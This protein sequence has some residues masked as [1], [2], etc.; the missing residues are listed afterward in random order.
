M[1][2]S[3]L[4]TYGRHTI[5][6]FYSTNY[7]MKWKR[8]KKRHLYNSIFAVFA[9]HFQGHIMRR[10][11]RNASLN[12][13][14][15]WIV[16]HAFS[17]FLEMPLSNFNFIDLRFAVELAGRV[18]VVIVKASSIYPLCNE[19]TG[20]LAALSISCYVQYEGTNSG[21]LWCCF[22]FWHASV[23]I[24]DKLHGAL[25]NSVPKLF[26]YWQFLCYIVAIAEIV[27]L[28]EFV[29]CWVFQL[30]YSTVQ[31]ILYWHNPTIWSLDQN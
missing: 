26:V 31:G 22:M 7:F 9:R 13:K 4:V 11:W 3:I 14:R 8:E 18:G 21:K 16:L 24:A 10:C 25:W 23:C 17:S 5:E 19:Q 15:V 20:M 2:A 29:W 1:H 27:K 28:H 6:S 12:E 30:C